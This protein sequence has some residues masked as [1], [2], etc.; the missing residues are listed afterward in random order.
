MTKPRATVRLQLHKGFDFDAAAAAVDYYAALGIS[1][2]YA[3]PLLTARKGSMHGYDV[4]DPTQINPELGGEQGLRR[5]VDK[6]R[7]HGM[8]L[9]ADIVPNHMGVGGSENPWWLQVLEWGAESRYAHWFD[10]DW[11]SP[12]PALHGKLL[13]PFLGEP[14]ADILQS[15]MLVPHFDADSGR[16]HLS[17]HEHYLPLAVDSYPFLLRDCPPVLAPVAAL[18]TA[19]KAAQ[20]APDNVEKP[21]RLAAHAAG[22]ALLQAINA[23][24]VGAAAIGAVLARISAGAA[25]DGDGMSGQERQH[26]LLERQNY[27]LTWWRNAAEEI[28]WRRFFEVTD[29]AGVRVEEEDVLAA[30]HE[31]IFWMYREG[32]IDGVRVDHVDGLARPAAY[33]VRLRKRLAAFESR[34][35]PYIVVE[36]ILARDETLCREWQV[37]GTTGYEFMDQVA[38]LFHNPEGSAPLS[39]LWTEFTGDELDFAAHVRAARRQILQQHLVGE[40]TALANALHA[41][42]RGNLLTR[43]IPLA[44]I[45]RVLTELLVNFPVYRTY[46]DE[47]LC[48]EQSR[49]ALAA[50]RAAVS[51]VRAADMP[52]LETMVGWL[53]GEASTDLKGAAGEQ[54]LSLQQ[55]V[56]TR[57]QQLTPPLAAKSTEDTAFYR[58]GRLLSRN[59]VGADPGE[60][61]LLPGD[62]HQANEMR[63]RDFPHSLLATATHDHK[64]GEDVRA[65]L[66]VLSEMPQAWAD[67]VWSWRERH[68]AH[69]IEQPA[70][71]DGDAERIP[72][73]ADELMLYQIIVGAWPPALTVDDTSALQGFAER[74]AAWQEKALR[75]AKRHT[76][77]TLPDTHYEGICREFVFKILAPDNREFLAEVQDWARRL[78]PGAVANSLGQTLLRM[79]APGVPDLYQGTEFWDFS[80]VD[81]DNRRPV[82]Y[83]QRREHLTQAPPPLKK[84][85]D[86]PPAEFKQSLI[87]K[88]LTLRKAHAALFAAGGYMPVHAEGEL[89]RHVFAFIR[90]NEESAVLV[91]VIR[92]LATV[93]L[94]GDLDWQDTV[95][96][97]PQTAVREWRDCLTERAPL[98]MQE[99]NALPLAQVL[100]G[101]PVALLGGSSQ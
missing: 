46:V 55:R 64:R 35:A 6:L 86:W 66:A 98:A 95:L 25:Q 39:A 53:S 65:R 1:H 60:L 63:L 42:A 79:T 14:Y 62:F 52:L 72:E 97:L 16:F 33:C 54:T 59:E 99:G 51:E 37:D 13:L 88:T 28:N 93:A 45:S 31:R 47:G 49:Q 5:L 80:L 85:R 70:V 82:D 32:L 22:R 34:P 94:E 38:A 75:E 78:T 12:D 57:F 15:G 7:A 9:I 27:R 74:V 101:S 83:V 48:D 68:A 17:Y 96:R 90:H 43:D 89:A 8:G 61:A 23:T 67:S 92:L 87:G 2:V 81:P 91:V 41:L 44:A 4:V 18:Y 77:W 29:L 71:N 56:V 69:V 58:Y 3:S 40:F 21:D 100:A 73:A 11:H 84:W 10:I 30:T 26:Q 24:P 19:L 50:A 20:A 36:K 76:S